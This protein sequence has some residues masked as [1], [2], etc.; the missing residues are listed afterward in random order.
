M[1]KKCST[2]KI[3]KDIINFTKDKRKKDGLKINCIECC[4]VLYN[5]YREKNY[6]KERERSKKYNREKRVINKEETKI[7]KKEYFQKNKEIIT[8]KRREKY[9]MNKDIINKNRSSNITKRLNNTIGNLIR[10]YLKSN[11]F[12]KKSRTYK[13]LGCSP[14]KLKIYLESRFENWMT[15]DNY[16]KYNSEL[17]YGWDID[18][19]IPISSAKTEE[20]ILKLNHYTNLQP[21]CS[22]TNRYV[23]INKLDFLK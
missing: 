3:E 16:G 14:L 20:E 23:K 21:L 4:K 18:H 22:Y 8:I 6:Q 12:Y 19:I 11:G 10:T 7:Y 15:W 13:I 9:N 2:C 17:C 1:M 5:N